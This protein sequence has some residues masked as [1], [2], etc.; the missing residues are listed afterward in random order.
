MKH[1]GQQGILNLI[2]GN[3]SV[4]QA[5]PEQHL[6][7][8]QESLLFGLDLIELVHKMVCGMN[9][10]QRLHLFHAQVHVHVQFN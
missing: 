8:L 9:R 3:Y 1:L 10:T 5:G 7:Q 4:S 6:L 2:E